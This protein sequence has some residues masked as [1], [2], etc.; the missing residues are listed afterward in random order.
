MIPCPIAG[1]TTDRALYSTSLT[2]AADVG[3]AGTSATNASRAYRLTFGLQLYA[4][5]ADVAHEACDR[6]VFGDART[7]S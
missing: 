2:I 5:V 3:Y 4:I 1:L 6:L 7:V